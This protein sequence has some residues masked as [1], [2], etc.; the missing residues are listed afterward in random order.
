MRR[1][2]QAGSAT[3]AALV[4]LVLLAAVA[5]GGVLIVSASL[6]RERHSVDAY[7]LRQALEK[8]GERVA[9]LLAEDPTPG[10]DSP[11]D[12]VW[13]GLASP[14]LE[15]AADTLQD[16]SSAVNPNWVQKNLFTKTGLKALLKDTGSADVLQQKRADLGFFI[17]MEQAYGDLFIK[18]ALEKYCTPYGYANINVTDEFA[19]RRLFAIR[20]GDEAAADVF[21]ARIQQLLIDQKILTPQD[22]RTFLGLDYDTLFPVMNVEPVMNAHFVDPLILG[23]LLVYPD[24]KVPQPQQAAQAILTMRTTVEMSSEQLHTLIGAPATSRI[25]QYLGVTTW[26]WK[27]TVKQAQE[28]LDMIVARMPVAPDQKARFTIVERRYSRG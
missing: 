17:N 5:G 23:E 11:Q 6:S 19:L 26:F 14:G 18:D 4:L 21:H 16:V 28:T 24:L 10:A 8:E 20:T 1:G 2:R 15:G 25:Y 13:D 7:A 27:V 3:I 9:A 12:P 22:L